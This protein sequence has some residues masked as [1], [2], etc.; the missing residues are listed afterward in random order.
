MKLKKISEEDHRIFL[1]LKWH[2]ISHPKSKL[3]SATV[4]V[5]FVILLMTVK[6][7]NSMKNWESQ[8]R[9]RE[10]GDDGMFI[11][12]KNRVNVFENISKD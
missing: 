9:V 11:D 2:R 1:L 6:S 7:E 10:G 3:N 8:S 12:S 4:D 5:L